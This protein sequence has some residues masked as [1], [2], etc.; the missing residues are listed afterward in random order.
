MSAEPLGVNDAVETLQVRQ[1]R[2]CACAAPR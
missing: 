1:Q 2:A